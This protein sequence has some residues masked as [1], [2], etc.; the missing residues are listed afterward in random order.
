[1]EIIDKNILDI[2]TGFIFHQVNCQK[3]MGS[4]LAAQIRSK[5][6]QVYDDYMNTC[7]AIKNDFELLGRYVQTETN[8]GVIVVS[9]FCQLYYGFDGRRYTDYCAVRRVLEQLKGTHTNR[10]HF[11]FGFGAGLGGGDWDVVKRMI[12]YYMPNAIVCKCPTN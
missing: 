6:P 2:N 3:R 1:M 4:G 5:Y 12:Q 11:P 7:C 8:S 10:Y 9:C